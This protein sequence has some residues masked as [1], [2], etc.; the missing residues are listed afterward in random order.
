MHAARR[1][2]ADALRRDVDM[3]N[4]AQTSDWSSSDGE[5]DPPL[6]E[7]QKVIQAQAEERIKHDLAGLKDAFKWS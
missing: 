5:D 4:G 6:T 1:E 3:V 2:A 7:E